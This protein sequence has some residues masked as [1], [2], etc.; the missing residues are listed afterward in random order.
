MGELRRLTG[1]DI[2]LTA[3]APNVRIH[4]V[5]HAEFQAIVRGI[6]P[7]VSRSSHLRTG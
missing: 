6:P 5:P 1:L 2:Q 4:F 7:A 3:S